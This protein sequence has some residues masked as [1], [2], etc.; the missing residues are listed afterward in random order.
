MYTI[1]VAIYYVW[2]IIVYCY[3]SKRIVFRVAIKCKIFFSYERAIC[4]IYMNK[5]NTGRIVQYIQFIVIY[6]YALVVIVTIISR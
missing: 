1:F 3:T 5:V 2:Y 6:I 4:M